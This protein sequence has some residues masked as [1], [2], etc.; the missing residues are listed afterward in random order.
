MSENSSDN[1]AS[2][3]EDEEEDKVDAAI[4]KTGCSV[5]NY[6]IQDCMFENKDWR[7][8]QNEVKA[9]KECIMRNQNKSTK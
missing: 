3:D 7:K 4:R 1:N 2:L 5:E 6:A 9:F 8:C